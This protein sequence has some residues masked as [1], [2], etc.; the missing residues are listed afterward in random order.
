MKTKLSFPAYQP[1]LWRWAI[2]LIV[3]LCLGVLLRYSLS[4]QFEQ[5]LSFGTGR[6]VQI[7]DPSGLNRMPIGLARVTPPLTLRSMPCRPVILSS[8]WRLMIPIARRP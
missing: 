4:A 7:V 3:V 2:A 8:A 6:G 1:R 5:G